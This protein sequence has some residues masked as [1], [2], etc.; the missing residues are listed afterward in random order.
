MKRYQ[1]L[2]A[3]LSLSAM[4]CDSSYAAAA[5][6]PVG[7]ESATPAATQTIAP[8]ALTYSYESKTYGYRIM[9]PQ[10]PVGVIP[11]SALY[12]D[13]EG[14]ILIFD[15][16]EYNIKYAW[17]VLVDAFSADALPNLNSIDR[18]QAE[19]LLKGIMGS[20]GYEGIMLVNL[21]ERNKAIFA[22]TAKEIEIDE[23]GDGVVDAAAHADT[24]MAVLFFRSANGERYGLELIDN[25]ELRAA[26]VS[27]FVEGARTLAGAQK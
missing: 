15:N 9:C 11:A 6:V 23:D 24:Q 19:T 1:K 25:P 4:L 7:T 13:R 18:E 27:A 3:V 5:D 10:K 17:V 8:D 16:E 22:M 21:T 14:E 12:D 2:V 20:N 26:S